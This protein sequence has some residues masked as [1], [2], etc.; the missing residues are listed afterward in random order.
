MCRYSEN[1]AGE[2]RRGLLQR[3]VSHG[4]CLHGTAPRSR[5]AASLSAVGA[6][7]RTIFGRDLE[8]DS[9]TRVKVE[10]L[11]REASERPGGRDATTS[12]TPA[13]PRAAAI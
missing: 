13:Q 3:G 6:V 7:Q 12:A 1:P 11:L 9:R 4:R 10:R 2:C 8:L 5:R